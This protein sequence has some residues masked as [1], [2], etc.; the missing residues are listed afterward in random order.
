MSRVAA[1]GEWEEQRKQRG[2]VDKQCSR[3]APTQSGG[4]PGAEGGGRGVVLVGR[5]V[6]EVIAQGAGGVDD[7]HGVDPARPGRHGAEG[8]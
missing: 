3:S 5:G 6:G 2:A 7:E 1:G 4:V 8:A